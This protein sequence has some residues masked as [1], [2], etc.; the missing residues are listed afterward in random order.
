MGAFRSD[1]LAGQVAFVTGGATGIG[2]GIAHVLGRHGARIAIASRKV[3]NLERAAA[4]F[5]AAGIECFYD[6]CD[7]REPEEVERVVAGVL[8]RFGS[9]DILV[10]N[11]AGN[12]PAPM[13]KISY[14]GFRAVVGID[15]LGTYNV[16]K[17]V[18]EAWM[19]D[20]GGNVVNISAPFEGMGVSLQSHVAAAKAGVDSLTRTC[21]VEWGPLGIRV[22]AIAP[23]EI[24]QTEGVARFEE[25]VGT[26]A[27]G[28]NPLGFAGATDDIG[29]VVLFL[30]SEASRFVSGQVFCVDGASGVDAF[31][32]RVEPPTEPTDESS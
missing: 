9:L 13:R 17:A 25:A 4:E 21:A 19:K 24:A 15:L 20:H 16:S 12:F 22:N 26:R 8:E 11:A 31:K 30:V 2:N 14:N 1:L 10:N 18:F 23:G 6:T 28:S 32:L 7:I 29:N 27:E 3:E 5:D